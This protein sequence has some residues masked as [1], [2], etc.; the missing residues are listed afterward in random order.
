MYYLE[1]CSYDIVLTV[2]RDVVNLKIMITRSFPV[3]GFQNTRIS[4]HY[5]HWSYSMIIMI[6]VICPWGRL[7]L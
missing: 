2:M 4:T 6:T 7:D 5:D 1:K 3:S